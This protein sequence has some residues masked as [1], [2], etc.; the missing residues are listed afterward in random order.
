MLRMEYVSRPINSLRQ[1][2]VE[3]PV[4]QG[5]SRRGSSDLRRPAFGYVRGFLR[6]VLAGRCCR[7]PL[8]NDCAAVDDPVGGARFNVTVFVSSLTA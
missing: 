7:H 4:M 2:A 6:T 3:V 8:E 1:R 5:T